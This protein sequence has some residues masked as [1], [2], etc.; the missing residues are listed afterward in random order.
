MRHPARCSLYIPHALGFA[1]V[2]SITCI[3]PSHA[4]SEPAEL[5]RTAVSVYQHVAG[6]WYAYLVLGACIYWLLSVKPSVYCVD[7]AV[8]HPPEDWRVSQADLV[9][10]LRKLGHYSEDSITFMARMLER[11][12]TGEATHWPGSTVRIIRPEIVAREGL[13]YGLN[14]RSASEASA[15]A[16]SGAAAGA[17]AVPAAAATSGDAA[18]AAESSGA[19]A[20][21]AIIAA[22]AELV[23]DISIEAAR[24][25]A[26]RVMFGVVDEVLR[27][28]G[29]K[30]RDI[31]FLIVNCSLFCPTPSLCSSIAKGFGMRPDIRSYNL[32]GMGCS[33]GVISIDLAKQLLQNKPHARALVVSFEEISQQLYTGNQRSMLLQNTLFRVG[34]AGVLLS[35]RPMDGFRAKYKLLHTVRVQDTS[36]ASHRCVYQRQDADGKLGI[37]LSK[38]ITNVAAKTLR[39]NLTLLGPHVL[40]IREQAKVLLSIASRRIATALNDAADALGVAKLPL[41]GSTGRLAK[42]P[43]YVPDFKLGLQHFCIHAGESRWVR[44]DR[45]VDGG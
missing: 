31:D 34:G 35:N 36:E 7:F 5:V 29:T 6:L 39:D 12:G 40:P 27:K 41:T 33:A 4:R 45:E 13:S 43:V 2:A 24:A 8:Y 26:E 25:N 30:P 16:A 19:S 17:G 21:P 10:V 23:A 22:R 9:A 1:L 3:L 32:G 20:V 37:E 38:D 28:T 14:A 42:P 44:G 15:A 18:G 11:S